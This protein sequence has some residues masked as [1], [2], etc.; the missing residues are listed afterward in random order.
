MAEDAARPP[1]RTLLR[2]LTASLERVQTLK[3]G[4]ANARRRS[5]VVDATFETIER[6]S[7][8]GG[9]MLA[10]ALSYRLFVFAL[11]LSVFFVAAGALLSDALGLEADVISS[12]VGFAGVVTKQV[13]SASDSSANWWLAFASLSVLVYGTRVLSRA[14]SIVHALAWERSAAAV[15]ATTR[16]LGVF[17]ACL[18]AQV[19]LGAGVGAIRHQTTLGGL[20]AVVGYA[21]AVSALWLVVSLH[22]PHGDARWH[23]L[24]PGAIFYGVG[25]TCVA[26][27][28]VLILGK[29]IESK[30]STYGALGVAATLLLGFFFVGRIIVGSAV[31]NATLHERRTRSRGGV[32]DG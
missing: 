16:G 17:A 24:L 11:P 10:A 4:I 13:A 7:D 28:N 27:F 21:V 9:A 26:A 32:A 15:R 23:E 18:L 30:A 8:L 14:V 31:L 20:L 1:R 25:L 6:D 2:R 22:V 29:L 19:L 12:S 5:T 3:T